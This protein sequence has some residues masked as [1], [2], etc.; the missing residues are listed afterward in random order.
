MDK[1]R[2]RL[3]TS[4]HQGWRS[5]HVIGHSY[6]YN[7]RPF[8]CGDVKRHGLPRCVGSGTTTA[9]TPFATRVSG[10]G[11]LADAAPIQLSTSHGGLAPPAPSLGW[12]RLPCCVAVRG[13]RPVSRPLCHAYRARQDRSGTQRGFLCPRQQCAKPIPR[14][15]TTQRGGYAI[16]YEARQLAY[17]RLLHSAVMARSKHREVGR[18][19]NGRWRWLQR[20]LP[21]RTRDTSAVARRRCART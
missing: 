10:A 8:S 1:R 4:A 6:V 17:S 20:E 18:R 13:W 7:R 19:G 14:S 12:D 2:K 3:C 16:A 21:R 11:T 15:L 9:R 5:G